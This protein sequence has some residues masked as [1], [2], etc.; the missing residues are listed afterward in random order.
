LL[1]PKIL[2]LDDSTS[3]VDAE[4]E[5]KIQQALDDLM[6]NRTSFVIAQRISTVRNADVILLLDGG[7]II[8]QGSHD[9][10][11]RDNAVYGDII[12]SQFG[13]QLAH[14]GVI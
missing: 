9:D 8:G 14:E 12:D 7:K 4:T 1:D 3:A 2:I 5:F 13:H 6:H 11:L 10:L